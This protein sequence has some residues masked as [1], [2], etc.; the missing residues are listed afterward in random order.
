MWGIPWW[1]TAAAAAFCLLFAV[2]SAAAKGFTGEFLWFALLA[3]LFGGASLMR[4]SW[5]R[6]VLTWVAT[7][8]RAR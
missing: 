4:S 5:L 2:M 7:M 8:F 3:A 1:L 6:D